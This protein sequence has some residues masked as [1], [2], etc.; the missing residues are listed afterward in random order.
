[1]QIPGNQ[2]SPKFQQGMQ[3]FFVRTLG[4]QE[5]II[6]FEQESDQEPISCSNQTTECALLTSFYCIVFGNKKTIWE[7]NEKSAAYGIFVK[8]E[9]EYRI[10]SSLPDTDITHRDVHKADQQGLGVFLLSSYREIPKISPGAYIFQRPFLRSLCLEG[11][12]CRGK[13]AFQN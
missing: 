13:F 8:K 9:P 1:M 3:D 10:R 7:S 2:D 5:I 12:I 4:I 11:L 6:M